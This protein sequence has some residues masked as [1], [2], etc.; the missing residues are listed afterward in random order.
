M[1]MD[2][3]LYAI[4]FW[5][6]IMVLTTWAYYEYRRK[7]TLMDYRLNQKEFYISLLHELRFFTVFVCLADLVIN[8]CAMELYYQHLLGTGFLITHQ[9]SGDNHLIKTNNVNILII[10]FFIA[11]IIWIIRMLRDKS[12]K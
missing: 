2:L 6:I 1:D 11:S 7:V 10:G 9:V 3:L 5:V 8:I 4:L 12:V